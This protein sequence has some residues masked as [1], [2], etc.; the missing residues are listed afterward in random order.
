VS[1]SEDKD[2]ERKENAKQMRAIFL[3]VFFSAVASFLFVHV[4]G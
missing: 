3:G 4:L 2:K 1:S